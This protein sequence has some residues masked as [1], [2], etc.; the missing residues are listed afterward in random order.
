MK[1]TAKFF[2]KEDLPRSLLPYYN[3]DNQYSI[4]GEMNIE[5]ICEIC[6]TKEMIPSVYLR[7]KIIK[8]RLSGSRCQSCHYNKERSTRWKGGKTKAGEYVSILVESTE[9]GQHK[10]KYALE[11]R[12]IMERLIGR[13]LYPYEN[14][15]HLNGIKTD[16]RPEN[17]ELWVQS[18]PSG[19]RKSEG[20]AHCTTCTCYDKS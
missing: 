17:L 4:N 9:K 13:P 15:H 5:R 14:V 18:Q 3:I 2:S 11:H 16:N 20:L 12:V 19:Q 10:T 8:G 1:A 7:R 6:Q